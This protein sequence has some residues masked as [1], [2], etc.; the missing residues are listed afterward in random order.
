MT[1]TLLR[2]LYPPLMLIGF[3]GLAI[4][5]I[6]ADSSHLL[7]M[8]LLLLAI[9]TSFAIE[10][11]IPYQDEWNESHGDSER[12]VAHA[13]VNE[14]ALPCWPFS[15]CRRSPAS[16]RSPTPGPTTRRSWSRCLE[17]FSSST[18]GSRSLTG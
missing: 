16:S 13:L 17:R 3:N 7:L 9:A 5:L 4:A 2:W 14:R 11:A 6:A 8:P 12:D 1:D 18:S 10:R 15:R